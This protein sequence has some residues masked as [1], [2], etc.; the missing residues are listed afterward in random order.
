VVVVR[1]RGPQPDA[2]VLFGVLL[3]HPSEREVKL[4]TLAWE[5]VVVD[6]LAKEGMAEA[7]ALVVLRANQM[8]A[9]RL[10]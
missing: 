3:E 1:G 9:E 10:A 5:E 2:V 7:K 8:G 6:H 4:R